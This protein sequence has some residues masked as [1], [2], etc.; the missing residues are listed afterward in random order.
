MC[1]SDLSWTRVAGALVRHVVHR[2]PLNAKCESSASP[3]TDCAFEV[4]D[5]PDGWTSAS[6][7]DAG[8]TPAMVY[9]AE[10]VGTKEGY[11]TVSWEP[12]AKLIWS[13]DLKVDNTV[14]WRVSVP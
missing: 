8:W 10:Q 13:S 12:S 3:A 11:D 5:E 2:A 1:S 14:L 7:D 4:T 9:T 6:F